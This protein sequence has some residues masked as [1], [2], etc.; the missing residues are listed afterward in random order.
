M[1]A[2]WKATIPLLILAL[3]GI[4]YSL[5]G[6]N[7][8]GLEAA[9]EDSTAPLAPFDQHI[10]NHAAHLLQ[11]GR[12]IFRFDTFGDEAFWGDQLQLHQAIATA[13]PKTALA[14]GLKVDVAALPPALL[15]QLQ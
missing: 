7:I 10:S 4:G 11:E 13:S 1:K 3:F 8:A 6:R 15:D 9:I 2:P 5:I 12:D 14:L